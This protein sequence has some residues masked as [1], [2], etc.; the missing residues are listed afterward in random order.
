MIGVMPDTRGRDAREQDIATTVS[1]LIH[2]VAA[3]PPFPLES[4][5]L[6]N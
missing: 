6:G 2:E 3:D 5:M 1:N 4:R